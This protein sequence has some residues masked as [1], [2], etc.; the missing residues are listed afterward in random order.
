MSSAAGATV[1]P[2]DRE[3]IPTM[4]AM[5][6]QA[7]TTAS[8][9]RALQSGNNAIGPRMRLT[10]ARFLRHLE[11]A[12]TVS[13]AAGPDSIFDLHTLVLE[14]AVRYESFARL[15]ASNDRER[16]ASNY[17]RIFD[18]ADALTADSA[19]DEIAISNT[20]HASELADY[21]QGLSV[22]IT[23]YIREELAESEE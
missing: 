5:A 13:E 17:S 4:A 20:E 8:V 9:I 22:L 19:T 2:E 15:A 11:A 1:A 3:V 14:D 21:L 6:V 7:S 10:V 12:K 18:L 16:I 23:N